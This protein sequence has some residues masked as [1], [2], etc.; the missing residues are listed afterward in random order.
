[1]V[2]TILLICHAAKVKATMSLVM[3][4]FSVEIISLPMM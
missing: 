2:N 4:I 3:A 1:M